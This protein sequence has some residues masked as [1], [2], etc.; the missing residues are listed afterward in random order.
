MRYVSGAALQALT[1]GATC[2]HDMLLSRCST[3]REMLLVLA[4]RYNY[5]TW[6]INDARELQ[7]L[8]GVYE[9]PATRCHVFCRLSYIRILPCYES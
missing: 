7:L 9:T 2:C 3:V 8:E 1:P 5:R 4:S 6:T